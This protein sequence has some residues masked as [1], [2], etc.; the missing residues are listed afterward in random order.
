MI[1]AI[2]FMGWRLNTL[3]VRLELRLSPP[4]AHA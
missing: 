3:M 1:L 2:S 4:A